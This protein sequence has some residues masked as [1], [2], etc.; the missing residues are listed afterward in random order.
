MSVAGTVTPAI[1]EV[2]NGTLAYTFSG[3]GSISGSVTLTKEGSGTLAMNMAGNTYSGGTGL[4]GGV[5]QIGANSTVSGGVLASGPL[6]TG[7]LT[8]SGGTLQDGGAGY[9]LA[10]ALN[11]NANVTL[12]GT[13]GLT[14]GPQ[15]LATPNTITITGSP[16]LYVTAPT[17]FADSVIGSTLVKDGPSTL[18]LAAGTNV[19]PAAAGRQRHA[20]GHGGQ[21]SPGRHLGQQRQRDLLP[22]HGR[23]A[24]HRRQ[25]HRHARQD[26]PGP[27]EHWHPATVHGHHRSIS[28]GTLQLAA[29]PASIPGL[30]AHYTFDGRWGRLPWDGSAWQRLPIQRQRQHLTLYSGARRVSSPA[31]ST[32]RSH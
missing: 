24:E 32:R 10:N 29:P 14:F 25:R 5:L 9:T 2:S 15:T 13:G 1:F 21:R 12:A 11:I 4:G 30:V 23:H 20:G 27:A 8:V 16:T 22:G 31:S 6:G 7:A 26:R 19:S 28:G 17:T 18:T 3:A